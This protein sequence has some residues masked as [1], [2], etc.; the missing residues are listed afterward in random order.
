[1]LSSASVANCIRIPETSWCKQVPPFL[2]F[3]WWW[4]WWW[5]WDQHKEKEKQ[6]ETHLE[7]IG[8]SFFPRCCV[9]CC[10]TC[11]HPLQVW[12]APGTLSLQQAKV[13]TLPANV[14]TLDLQQGNV[15]GTLASLASLESY[16]FSH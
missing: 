6:Q 13:G 14:G 4:L 11:L 5:F 10:G 12:L 9:I 7:N 15:G 1:M 3:G 2:C 8:V 16:F